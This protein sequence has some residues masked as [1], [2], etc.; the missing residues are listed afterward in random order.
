MTSRWI[1]STRFRRQAR[2][3]VVVVHAGGQRQRHPASDHG[4]QLLLGEGLRQVVVHAGGEAGFAVALQRVGGDGD[5]R[6]HP[7]APGSRSS[8]RIAAVAAKP[9]ITGIWQSIS[10]QS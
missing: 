7:S 8:R 9:S 6:Q 1:T 5:D 3:L 4:G 2:R 10:T